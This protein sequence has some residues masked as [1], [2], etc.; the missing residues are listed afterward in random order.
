MDTVTDCCAPA[1]DEAP[2]VCCPAIVDEP[3]TVERADRLA[4]WFGVLSDPTRLRLLSLIGAKGEAC[5]ACEMVEPLGVS[6]PTVS[7]HLK[8][9]RQAG[10]VVSEKRGRWVYYR[11]VAQRLAALSRVLQ[12]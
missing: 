2:A 11:T 5:A 4:G 3:L 7:H 9:L 8:I 12:A 1:G 10:L 6:Q